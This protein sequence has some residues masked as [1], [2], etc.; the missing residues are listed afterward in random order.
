VTVQNI[1]GSFIVAL[2][3]DSSRVLHNRIISEE[4][5]ALAGFFLR[6]FQG[7]SFRASRRFTPWC[8]GN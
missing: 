2:K 7:P 4:G 1:K 6:F 8:R 3:D 5:H